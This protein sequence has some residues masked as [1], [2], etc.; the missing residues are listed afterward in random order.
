MSAGDGQWAGPL[1]PQG[2]IDAMRA[3]VPLG[4]DQAAM[5][6]AALAAGRQMATAAERWWLDPL[7]T[8]TGFE[9]VIP[10]EFAGWAGS[11]VFVELA[12]AAA[13]SDLDSDG[14]VAFSD[15]GSVPKVTLWKAEPASG[16]FAALPWATP[17][18]LRSMMRWF[19]IVDLLIVALLIVGVIVWRWDMVLWLV[20]P[21]ILLA[22]EWLLT[23]LPPYMASRQEP[24]QVVRLLPSG[25]TASIKGKQVLLPRPGGRPV[26]AAREAVRLAGDTVSLRADIWSRVWQAAAGPVRPV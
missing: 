17:A 23:R 8:G 24:R 1:T 26:I 18:G 12:R 7:C 19:L 6:A 9:M 3:S 15:G 5:Q 2:A 22:V 25:W 21:A 11:P 4:Q 10:A 14:W 20:I 13:L 16:R